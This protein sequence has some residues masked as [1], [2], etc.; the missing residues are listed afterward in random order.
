MRF[1]RLIF[2]IS[3]AGIIFLIFL[4]NTINQPKTATVKEI[5]HSSSR[6]IITLEENQIPLILF[7][8]K[9]LSLKKGDKI[10]FYG[11]EERYKGQEQIIINKIIKITN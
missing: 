9:P 5:T 1:S 7:N 2:L 6:T 3:I 11:Y 8:Q 10:K 4:A